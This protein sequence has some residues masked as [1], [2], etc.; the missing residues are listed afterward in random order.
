MP[1][2]I[3]NHPMDDMTAITFM[4]AQHADATLVM[5]VLEIMG[6]Q[7]FLFNIPDFRGPLER[8]HYPVLMVMTT[9]PVETVMRTVWAVL[10]EVSRG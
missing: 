5:L 7:T 9:A 4:P 2:F 8:Q 1:G 10:T 6:H 3:H